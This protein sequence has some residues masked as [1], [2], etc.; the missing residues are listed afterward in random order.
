[1]NCDDADGSGEPPTLLLPFGHATG[2][3]WGSTAFGGE[4]GY[5]RHQQ[6]HL[7]HLWS[8]NQIATSASR[9]SLNIV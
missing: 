3:G 4:S 5:Q 2:A 9:G 6:F 7:F 1:M 8:R